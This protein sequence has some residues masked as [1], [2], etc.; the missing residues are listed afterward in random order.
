M[1]QPDVPTKDSPIAEGES[2]RE[3][4]RDVFGEVLERLSYTVGL[5][6]VMLILVAIPALLWPRELG[7]YFNGYTYTVMLVIAYF[8]VP[9]VRRYMP[10]IKGRT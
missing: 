10:R 3:N 5:G 6:S 1:T 9:L 4:R 8:C 2:P 7:K